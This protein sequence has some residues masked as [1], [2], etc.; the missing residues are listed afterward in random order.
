[1]RTVVAIVGGSVVWQRA[2]QKPRSR[3]TVAAR[4][5]HVLIPVSAVNAVRCYQY[6]LKKGDLLMAVASLPAL[7]RFRITN[8]LAFLAFSKTGPLYLYIHI[9]AKKVCVH[10]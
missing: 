2:Q 1:M 4:Q 5:V 9:S 7:G 10:F 6:C 8:F 3:V